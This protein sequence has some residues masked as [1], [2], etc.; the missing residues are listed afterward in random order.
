MLRLYP[1]LLVMYAGA[2]AALSKRKY[3]TL[4]RLLLDAKVLDPE[5]RPAGATLNTSHVIGEIKVQRRIPG[6]ERK[7]AAGSDSL[8]KYLRE[9]LKDLIPNDRLYESSFDHFEVLLTVFWFEVGTSG[10]V[11]IGRYLASG[12][13]HGG[14]IPLAVE[15][16]LNEYKN[17]KSD[18]W[19]LRLGL[20]GTDALTRFNEWGPKIS[21]HLRF[22]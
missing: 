9:P 3:N 16:L 11:P 4:A 6:V 5:S 22:G 8:F 21:F 15:E 2:I 1:A 17:E 13:W 20:F 19:P 18:W 7:L 14:R 12:F 10:D